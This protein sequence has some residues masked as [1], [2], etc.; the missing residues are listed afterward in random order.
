MIGRKKFC[1]PVRATPTQRKG[2]VV[3]ID[4]QW[5]G[6]VFVRNVDIGKYID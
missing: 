6:S 3:R 1:M 2:L 5:F 4:G